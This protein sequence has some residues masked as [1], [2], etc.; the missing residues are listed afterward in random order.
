MPKA[1]DTRSRDAGGCFGTTH[2]IKTTKISEANT[3]AG[4]DLISWSEEEGTSDEYSV[5]G[6]WEILP[7]AATY[8]ERRGNKKA[9]ERAARWMRCEEM[10]TGGKG[11]T[12]C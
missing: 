7:P 9:R 12:R 11:E 10:G 3:P 2:T 4:D 1:R 6:E 8:C 5:D